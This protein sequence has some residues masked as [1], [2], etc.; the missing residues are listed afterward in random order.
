LAKRDEKHETIG[1]R[2]RLILTLAFLLV[3]GPVT[4]LQDKILK[5]AG[6]GDPAASGG[7][8]DGAIQQVEGDLT[9]IWTADIT[10]RE[11][12]LPR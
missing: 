9:E 2:A 8:P 12:F 1:A 6:I 3:L 11:S 4:E 10:A 5:F 7:P